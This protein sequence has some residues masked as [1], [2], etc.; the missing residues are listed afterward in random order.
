MID[1]TRQKVSFF[2]HGRINQLSESE[3]SNLYLSPESWKSLII[4]SRSDCTSCTDEA[5]MVALLSQ[6]Y[7]SINI[8]KDRNIHT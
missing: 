2:S 5:N 7:L 8:F 6:P 1:L 4:F 3:I